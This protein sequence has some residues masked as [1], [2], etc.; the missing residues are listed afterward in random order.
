M[1]KNSLVACYLDMIGVIYTNKYVNEFSKHPYNNNLYGIYDFLSNYKLDLRAYKAAH[2]SDISEDCFPF[3]TL[4][5][6]EFVIVK[7]INDGLL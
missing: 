6:H 2:L 3:I 5:N 7:E 4:L 1:K